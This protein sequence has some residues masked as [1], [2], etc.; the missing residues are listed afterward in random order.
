M[1]RRRKR[2]RPGASRG[3]NLSGLSRPSVWRLTTPRNAPSSVEA[4]LRNKTR[5]PRTGSQRVPYPPFGGEGARRE[6][7]G[8]S[9]P[10]NKTVTPNNTSIAGGRTSVSA[11]LDLDRKRIIPM[12]SQETWIGNP[13]CAPHREHP[14]KGAGNRPAG[15][16]TSV[17]APLDLDRKRIIP[18]GSQETWIGNPNVHPTKNTIR[19]SHVLKGHSWIARGLCAALP[20]V[21]RQSSISALKGL[22]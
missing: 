15:G 1:G 4:F 14:S 3:I 9:R 12:G 19:P 18:M 21:A 20:W 7:E 17:S 22:A 2:S 16:R 10:H 5:A 6:G 8:A 13:Q 11:P